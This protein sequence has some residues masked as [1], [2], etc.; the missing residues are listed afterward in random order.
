MRS[1]NIVISLVLIIAPAAVALPHHSVAK[2][3]PLFDIECNQ[4]V[5]IPIFSSG[6]K[7][8]VDRVTKSATKVP[9]FYPALPPAGST[10]L[11]FCYN[12]NKT[13]RIE[14][15]A[16][17]AAFFFLIELSKHNTTVFGKRNDFYWLDRTPELQSRQI[18]QVNFTLPFIAPASTGI[19]V[20]TG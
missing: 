10:A 15:I 17:T 9:E 19:I 8:S 14:R 3:N 13:T 4:S 5:N 7:H 16:I 2:C 18:G 11:S 20:N 6:Y 12:H 1:R